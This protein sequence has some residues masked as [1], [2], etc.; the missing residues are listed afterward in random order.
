MELPTN[1]ILLHKQVQLFTTGVQVFIK[2]FVNNNF[3]IYKCHKTVPIIYSPSQVVLI[4]TIGCEWL[5]I[6]TRFD[7]HE[8]ARPQSMWSSPKRR[9]QPVSR[10][11]Y[12]SH[13]TGSDL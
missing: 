4:I 1:I 11:F 10:L 9:Q 8:R 7:L 12:L 6:G 5:S 13:A 3:T 2:A